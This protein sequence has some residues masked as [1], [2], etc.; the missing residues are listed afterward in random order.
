MSDQSLWEN[1]EQFQ[2]LSEEESETVNAGKSY[3]DLK[4]LNVGACPACR[5]GF[6]PLLIQ[7]YDNIIPLLKTE[8][9]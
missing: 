1:I 4:Y 6:D 2:E 5:S 9:V 7:K 8:R 3:A